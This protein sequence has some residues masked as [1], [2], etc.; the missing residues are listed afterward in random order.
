MK[1]PIFY[2]AG[3]TDALRYARNRLQQWGYAISPVPTEQ[4]THLLLPVPSFESPGILKGG[5]SLSDILKTL[6]ENI[7][8]LG[9]GLPALPY[10]YA[11]FLKDE[12][13][14]TENAAITAHCAVKLVQ[15]KYSGV[16]KD[17]PVLI[18]GWG[19]IG[20]QL[21]PLLNATGA[22]VTVAVRKKRDVEALQSIHCNATLIS[23]LCPKQ[24]RIILNTAPALILQEKDAQP[25]ALLIDL[26]SVQGIQGNR[27]LWARGLPNKDA[28]QISGN[29]IAK[30]ALRY[31][32][33]KE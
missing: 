11:D 28:P 5:A 2:T 24:Y 20:K 15:Q 10:R 21:V 32:L 30:T 12:F 8:I 14:L 19:R 17:V 31:A 23:H 9:G 16:L 13:Y 22:I 18:I 1:Q 3:D 29:L 26:A 27:V 33:G 6:P 4:V 7:T 25:D